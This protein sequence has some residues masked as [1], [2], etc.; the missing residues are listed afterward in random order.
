MVAAQPKTELS[1]FQEELGRMI[2]ENL[3]DEGAIRGI[4]AR[5]TR[6]LSIRV[7]DSNDAYQTLAM[8]HF[9]NGSPRDCINA[10]ENVKNADGLHS[11]NYAN[12]L[13]YFGNFGHSHSCLELCRLVLDSI[14][15]EKGALKSALSF[16]SMFCDFELYAKLVD[17][18]DNLSINDP[19]DPELAMV[20]IMKARTE[21]RMQALQIKGE[22]V[23]D[24]LATVIDLLEEQGSPVVRINASTLHDGSFM[25]HLYVARD[26]DSCSE[27]NF[28][29][30][31]KL[32]SEFDDPGS[33]LFS[34]VCR[35]LTTFLLD[36][37][38]Q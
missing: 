31:E 36:G 2:R 28:D 1:S 32:C 27:L 26:M 23:R 24:R 4:I 37:H 25:Y 38:Q 9:A 13:L 30:A 7:I 14:G 21:K 3:K 18:I 22:E 15:D 8:A 5:V 34:V 20:K 12:F 17:R 33:E 29:V 11:E 19:E 35:P 16:S 6:L 10:I